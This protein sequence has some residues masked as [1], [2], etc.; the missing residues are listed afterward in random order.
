MRMSNRRRTSSAISGRFDTVDDLYRP[1]NHCAFNLISA[2]ALL[3]VFAKS[4]VQKV[5]R[6]FIS[7]YKES[8]ALQRTDRWIDRELSPVS[9]HRH[10]Y[11]CNL[12]QPFFTIAVTVA[13]VISRLGS[14]LVSVIITNKFFTRAPSGLKRR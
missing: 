10:K 8:I 12:P 11:T 1:R 4:I 2:L 14:F 13:T 9:Q 3:R 7:F 5:S 6:S